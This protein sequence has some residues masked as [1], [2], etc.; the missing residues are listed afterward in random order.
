MV[1]GL[2]S[3]T[4]SLALSDAIRLNFTPVHLKVQES[5]VERRGERAVGQARRKGEWHL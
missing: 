5:D 1:G 2:F 3:S 4:I